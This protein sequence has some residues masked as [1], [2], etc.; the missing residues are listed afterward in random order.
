[1]APLLEPQPQ[2]PN[3]PNST[4][5]LVELLV[6][7]GFPDTQAPF[8]G[9]TADMQE[10]TLFSTVFCKVVSLSSCADDVYCLSITLVLSRGLLWETSVVLFVRYFFARSPVKI[11][12]PYH[13]KLAYYTIVNSRGNNHLLLQFLNFLSFLASKRFLLLSC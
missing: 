2:P 10:C 5:L 12:T 6:A 11:E 9:A 4:S 1:M 3:L 7:T 8:L 13:Q